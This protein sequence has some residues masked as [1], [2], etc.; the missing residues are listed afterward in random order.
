MAG[1]EVHAVAAVLAGRSLRRRLVDRLE[2]SARA[3][4][5]GR[6]PWRARLAEAPLAEAT[7]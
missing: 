6:N 4:L 1:G 5:A 3:E 2:A 7:R